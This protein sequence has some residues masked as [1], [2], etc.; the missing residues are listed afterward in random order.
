MN[1]R[2][3]EKSATADLGGKTNKGIY[4]ML[5]IMVSELPERRR[6]NWNIRGMCRDW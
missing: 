3:E 2:M 1:K 6:L 5:L 4:I